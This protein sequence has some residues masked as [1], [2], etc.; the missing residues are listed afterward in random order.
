MRI[1]AED[2]DIRVSPIHSMPA[3]VAKHGIQA[4]IPEL[5]TLPVDMVVLYCAH[6]RATFG[7]TLY[8]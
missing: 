1:V 2:Y 7:T 4:R 3:L 6:D 8:T 5:G